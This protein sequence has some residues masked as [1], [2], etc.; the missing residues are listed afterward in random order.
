MTM[1]TLAKYWG[2]WTIVWTKISLENIMKKSF[3]FIFYV[4]ESVT[5]RDPV[6]IESE[7]HLDINR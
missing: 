6:I 1:T 5:Y 3:F 7:P 4:I 2:K